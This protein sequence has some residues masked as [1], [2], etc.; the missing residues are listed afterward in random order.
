MQVCSDSACEPEP[1]VELDW[2]SDIGWI[3]GE[4]IKVK[5]MQNIIKSWTMGNFIEFLS[6]E[7]YIMSC[8]GIVRVI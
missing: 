3:D 7:L 8:G 5:I 6:V 4:L 1:A 2:A